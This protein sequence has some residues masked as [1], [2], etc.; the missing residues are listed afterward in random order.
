M[1]VLLTGARAPA[2]LELARLAARAGYEVHVADTHRW[3]ICRASRLIAGTHTLP[4]P[5]ANQAAYASAVRALVARLG[6][7]VIVPTCE[8]VFHL[9]ALRTSI[10]ARLVCEPIERLGQLHDKWLFV[11]GCAEA[12][13][14]APETVAL[15]D[16]VTVDHL[17]EGEYIL[18]PRFSRFATRILRWRTGDAPPPGVSDRSTTWIAQRYL[19]GAALCTWS[20]AAHGRLLAHA[21]YAVDETAGAHGAAIA[22]HSVRHAAIRF[23]VEAFVAHHRLSGQLAF[24]FIEGPLGLHGIECNPRLTSGVHCFRSVPQVARVL[25]EP[26]AESGAPILEPPEGVAFRSRLALAMY[27]KPARDGSGLLDADDDPWPRRLQGVTW[28]HLLLRA[29]LARTDPRVL[30]TRDIEWNG[31]C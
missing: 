9:A 8:E 18:K 7:D 23:W 2:T 3:H 24:D 5:R 26:A 4:A 14:P 19:P 6:I 25:I 17:P 11:A 28:A 10:G 22:F 15:S 20:V 27:D 31:E 16:D 12:G 30:S 29:V 21:T 13:V 1:R